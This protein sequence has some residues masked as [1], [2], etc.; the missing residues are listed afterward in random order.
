MVTIMFRQRLRAAV[1][2]VSLLAAGG[3]SRP[4]FAA[5]M[6]MD[7]PNFITR[8]MPAVVN[9]SILK[10]EQPKPPGDNQVAAQSQRPSRILG[11][12]FIIDSSGII[13]TNKHVVE[14]GRDITVTMQDN[15]LLHATI[16][17]QAS[18]ADLAIIKVDADRPLPVAVFGDS[19]AVHVGDPVVAIGNPLGLGGSVTAGI[20]SALN[21]DI[22]DTPY[23]DYLQTD[24]AIN[25]GNSGGPLVNAKGEVIGVNTAIYSPTKDGG[26]IG[27][28][29]SMPSNDVKFIVDR[30]R[31]LGRVRP[32]Y[33]AVRVQQVT[34]QIA[35]AL[36]M[37]KAEGAIV[38]GMAEGG[39]ADV[40]GLVE[41]DI[42]LK[43]GAVET[44]DV[45]AVMRA[46][47]RSEVGQTVNFSVWRDGVVKAIPVTIG[48]MPEDKVS[49][50]VASVEQERP[51]NAGWK[52]SGLT[53]ETRTQFKLPKDQP[54][55]VITELAPDGSAADAGLSVGDVVVKL[56]QEAVLQP[57]DVIKALDAARVQKRHYALLLVRGQDGVK[58]VPLDLQR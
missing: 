31:L 20:V 46:V 57:D 17:A 7:A 36:G 53:D 34:P 19:D 56:Q 11:S 16:I 18:I 38:A 26:S 43:V 55:V 15:T 47:G 6:M 40:S 25:H 13:V 12:G 54:G 8:A 27:L 30:L 28:G 35:D 51:M 10:A 9:I 24:A 50:A 14:G 32:G 48:E 39:M 21:R 45:R 5:D 33:I 4:A 3:V 58:W 42:V 23:D 22:R 41:G 2:G 49:P 52:L 1:I 37:R 29:F 44:H